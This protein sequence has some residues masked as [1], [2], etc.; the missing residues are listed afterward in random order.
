MSELDALIQEYG[1]LLDQERA[2]D[3]RKTELRRRITDELDRLHIQQT[4]CVFGSAEQISR[5]KLTPRR[6]AVL[7]LLNREDLF[8]FA[9]FTPAKVKSVLVPKY[10]RDPLVPLFDIEKSVTLIVK[11]APTAHDRT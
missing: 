4:K 5:F 11:R 10:G 1:T 9:Q 6:D 3:L 2:I 7:A 8:P